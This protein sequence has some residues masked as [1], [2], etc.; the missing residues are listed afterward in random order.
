[1]RKAIKNGVVIPE[2]EA[3]I[4]VTDRGLQYSYS[5]YEYLRIKQGVFVHL[6]EHIARLRESLDG[7]GLRIQYSVEDIV[8]SLK[9]LCKEENLTD[10]TFRILIVG[11][12]EGYYF[13]THFPHTACPDEFYK[14][15]IKCTTFHGERYLPTMK[16]GNLLMQFLALKDAESK[17]CYEGLLVNSKG[18]VTEG[19]RSNFYG[20]KDG[21]I[22]TASDDEVLHGV[23]RLGLVD[24]ARKL[25][26]PIKYEPVYATDFEKY[27][28][29]F[30]TSTSMKALP[31]DE[32]DGV[33][34]PRKAQDIVLKLSD[35]IGEWE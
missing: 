21:V 15:G 29:L 28:S 20:I 32:I 10:E 25:G 14:V 18:Y 16:T 31:I 26:I 2:S 19:T 3:V 6:D 27:D 34:M 8:D 12:G 5:V 24:S 9:H 11:G 4:P 30:I 17:G 7:I 13:I 22:Y 35:L 1:M 33:K 23:T